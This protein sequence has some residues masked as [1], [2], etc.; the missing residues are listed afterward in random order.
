M[1]INYTPYVN[2]PVL[3]QNGCHCV[4][5]G[6]TFED[7]LNYVRE[8]WVEGE[9]FKVEIQAAHALNR[10]IICTITDDDPLDEVSPDNREIVKAVLTLLAKQK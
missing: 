6:H 9:G 10:I 7:A 5:V 4:Y 3:T 8:N 2:Y 1:K